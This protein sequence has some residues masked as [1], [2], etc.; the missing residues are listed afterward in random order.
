MPYPSPQSQ[1]QHDLDK[2]GSPH[3]CAEQAGVLA[4]CPLAAP[5]PDTPRHTVAVNEWTCAN[6]VSGSV[7]DRLPTYLMQ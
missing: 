1:P 3:R 2:V 4:C 5:Q 6:W 7:L